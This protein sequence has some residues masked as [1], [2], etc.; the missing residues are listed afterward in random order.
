VP[1]IRGRSALRAVH[2]SGTWVVRVKD[3]ARSGL[4]PEGLPAKAHVRFTPDRDRVTDVTEIPGRA[5]TGLK[6][7]NKDSEAFASGAP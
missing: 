6:H 7:C 4:H 1:D 3:H 2:R 5:K